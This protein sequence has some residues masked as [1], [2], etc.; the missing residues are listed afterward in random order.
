MTLTQPNAKELTSMAHSD[1]VDMFAALEC[2]TLSE[3]VGEFDGTPLQ[4]PNLVR[5]AVAAAKVRNRL[6]LWQ[7][8]GFRQIDET[9]GRGYNVYRWALTGSNHYSDP[10][11]TLIAPSAIDGRPAFQLDYRTFNTFCGA[12]N[13]VDDVRRVSPGLYLGF[14]MLGFTDRQRR[15]LQPFMLEATSRPYAGDIGTPRSEKR[16]A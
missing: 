16:R 15:V 3:M 13:L 11:T 2:P 4:Q 1:L 10:M 6:H 9:S 12:T 5:S 8:K 7:T 14:A